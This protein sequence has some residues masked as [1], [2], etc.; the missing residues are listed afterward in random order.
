MHEWNDPEVVNAI[1]A[2]KEKLGFRAI[3]HDTH[4]RA[5]TSPR[6]LLA[7][8]LHLFDGVLAFGDAIRRIYSDGFG[9]QHV[10]T[11]HEAAD[12]EHFRP[13]ASERDADVSGSAI[14]ATKSAPASWVNT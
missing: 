3:L 10:W 8:H 14:G 4:H 2:L 6:D 13:I 12:V 1:L 5:Y 7:F 9:M 11:F